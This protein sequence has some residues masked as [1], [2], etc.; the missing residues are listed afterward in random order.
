MSRLAA[1][2]RVGEPA[3]ALGTER[4]VAQQVADWFVTVQALEGFAP[5][6]VVRTRRVKRC[7]ELAVV[8]QSLREWNSNV[9]PSAASRCS[10]QGARVNS[11][12]RT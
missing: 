7:P 8:D 6:L 2:Q 4:S 5:A 3:A 1:T 9:R 12:P 10:K 11:R